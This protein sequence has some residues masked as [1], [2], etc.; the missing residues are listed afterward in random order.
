MRMNKRHAGASALMALA[1]LAGCSDVNQLLGNEESVDYKSTRRGDPL[2]IPPDL[3]QA[4]NDPRYKAPASG[5]ATYSQFQQQGLQQ[6]ASAGQNTNVLPERA[7][8]RVERDGDLR[9]LVIERP[10]EQ[11]FP[12]VV[13]FWTDTGFTV[14]VNN[15]QAG[16]IETDWAENRAKIPESWLRQVLG[17]VL[18]TAWDSGERE[19]FRTRVER[20]NGHTEIYITHNQML[21][22][23]VGSDGGQVQWTHGKEDPGLNAA[24]LARLMVYL[25]TDVDAARKLVAQAEAAPQAPKVQSVRAEGAMLVVDESFDRAW[26]RVGVALDSGGF[27]VDDRDRSAGEYFVRYVDTD[28]GAQN[29]QPGFFSRLFSSDKKAQAP[30]YRIRLT[31]SGTQTQVTVLDANG[32]R[33]SSATAQRMLSVL[34]DKMV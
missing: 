8:M 23:R 3:T 32:Q 24:M 2:S 22:K 20:V 16:I 33:D 27:A 30:Q 21:E 29:E 9:W 17:S 28:T 25:G 7:D 4:N 15:P 19:K 26:R 13:D 10:P 34:K 14:S 31:G 18:E 6:Q 12:K 5:T 11:L 1:L